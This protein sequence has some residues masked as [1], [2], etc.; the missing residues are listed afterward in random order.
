M[1]SPRR[2]SRP[3]AGAAAGE[4]PGSWAGL[5]AGFPGETEGRRGWE[6]VTA[7]QAGAALAQPSLGQEGI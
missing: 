4:G 7:P 2:L 6:R 1:G 5:R 3:R